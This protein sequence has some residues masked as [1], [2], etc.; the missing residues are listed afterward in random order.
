MV[1]NLARSDV[2]EDFKVVLVRAKLA[3]SKAVS[4]NL[5]APPCDAQRVPSHPEERR[6]RDQW[7]SYE[8]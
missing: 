1:E 3:V 5:R 6:R 8:A 2:F 7:K 4:V